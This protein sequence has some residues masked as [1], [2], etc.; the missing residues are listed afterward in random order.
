MTLHSMK[1]RRRSLELSARKVFL[2]RVVTFLYF[3]SATSFLFP[4][5]WFEVSTAPL[6]NI[7]YQRPNNEYSLMG[8]VRYWGRTTPANRPQ[9]SLPQ[10]LPLQRPPQR[11]SLSAVVIPPPFPPPGYEPSFTA[12][13]RHRVPEIHRPLPSIAGEAPQPAP[14]HSET[15]RRQ[16]PPH[17]LPSRESWLRRECSIPGEHSIR[18]KGSDCGGGGGVVE[19][20]IKS[21]KPSRPPRVAF[22]TYH[23]LACVT[24][25]IVFILRRQ[26]PPLPQPALP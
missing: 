20:T 14:P 15:S 3:A 16:A 2:P 1:N 21:M 6:V 26:C 24:T 12:S 10:R 18:R 19:G 4:D 23:T 13:L 25:P 22:R 8:C 9:E 7:S 11:R 17:A 5:H